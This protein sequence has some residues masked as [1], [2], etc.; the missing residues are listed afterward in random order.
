MTQTPA[1]W[2]TRRMGS[3]AGAITVPRYAPVIDPGTQ[4]AVIVD[5]RGRTV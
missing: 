2:G 4:I 5:A 3:Y 1:P